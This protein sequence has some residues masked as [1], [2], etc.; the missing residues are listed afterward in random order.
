[1]KIFDIVGVIIL[2]ILVVFVIVTLWV[3]SDTLK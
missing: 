1:M 2:S 3:E